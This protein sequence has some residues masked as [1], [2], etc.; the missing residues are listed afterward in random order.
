MNQ[1]YW[2]EGGAWDIFLYQKGEKKMFKKSNGA[3]KENT[4]ATLMGLPLF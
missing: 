2:S 4:G 3:G 1:I